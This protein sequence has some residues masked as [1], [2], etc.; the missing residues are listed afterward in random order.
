MTKPG[1]TR[2]KIVSSKKPCSARYWK[3]AAVFG[4]RSSKLTVKL[5]QLVSKTTP[6]AVGASA[7]GG[8]SLTS[9]FG[10]GAST[11]SHWEPAE[12][13]AEVLPSEPSSPQAVSRAAQAR[14]SA[15]ISG[16]RLSTRGSLTCC[17]IAIMAA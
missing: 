5:P 17:R 15:T 9:F 2:W 6:A 3:E 7:F 1:T 4:A 13:S 10:G 14:A 16:I 8:A 12:E 11:V